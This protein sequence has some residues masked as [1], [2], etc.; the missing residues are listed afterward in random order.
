M[1]P[2]VDPLPA[3]KQRILDEI[4]VLLEDWSQ[5]S[6]A[7]LLRTTQPRVSELRRGNVEH[8]SLDRL[9]RYLSHLGRE[10]ELV[11]T[12]RPGF[13]IHDRYD[14][15]LEAFSRSAVV[16]PAGAPGRGTQAPLPPQPQAHAKAAGEAAG[17]TATTRKLGR[18]GRL[19]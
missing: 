1:S 3:L 13:E 18:G 8:F 14:P 7:Q 16:A 10:V 4:L 19:V 5:A 2:R 6:A 17:R 11:T 15:R 12:R 9:V